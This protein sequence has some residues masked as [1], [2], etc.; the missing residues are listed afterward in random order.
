MN[1]LTFWLSIL[2]FTSLFGTFILSYLAQK[3]EY[4]EYRKQYLWYVAISWFWFVLQFIGFVH[5]TFLD[6]YHMVL[7]TFIGIMR[8]VIS[9]IIIYRIVT[10]LGSI[11]Q[12]TVSNRVKKT[13]FLIASGIAILVVPIMFLN[14][15]FLGPLFTTLVNVAIGLAFLM[16]RIRTTKVTTYRVQRMQSFM[17]ISAIAYLLFGLYALLFTFF[18][19]SYKPVY[20]SLATAIFILIW[21][22]NDVLMYLREASSTERDPIVDPLDFFGT[23]YGLSPRELQIVTYLVKGHPYK[24]IAGFLSIS[25]RT[26]ETHVYR[27]CKKCSVSNRAELTHSFMQIRNTT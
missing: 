13:G 16:Y 23:T 8:V 10:L 9:I 27:I 22:V 26:V 20:D 4:E 1:L 15:L 6:S 3:E 18:P 19:A 11:E 12:G 21:C 7:L 2:G 25:T 24:E 17:S 5:N 14:I